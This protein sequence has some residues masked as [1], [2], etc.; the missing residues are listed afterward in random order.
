MN[1]SE[2]NLSV[3]S[4]NL[5]R[6]N[7]ILEVEVLIT[8]TDDE[9][10]TLG[11]GRQA[12]GEVLEAVKLLRKVGAER[13]NEHWDIHNEYQRSKTNKHGDLFLE[14]SETAELDN[15]FPDEIINADDYSIYDMQIPDYNKL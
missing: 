6:R 9:V 8:M 10:F 1:I 2:L 4:Y 12:T 13:F 14:I 7:G 15:I 11:K 5:L 3:R